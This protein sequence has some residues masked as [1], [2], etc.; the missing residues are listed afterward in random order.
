MVKLFCD[1]CYEEVS[2]LF[3]IGY[4]VESTE[5]EQQGS[6]VIQ[7]NVCD[8]CSKKI[9][10]VIQFTVNKLQEENNGREVKVKAK[11]QRIQ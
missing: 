4:R 5:G 11:R 10:K 6:T 9:N 1:T 7:S 3:S 2:E 8:K